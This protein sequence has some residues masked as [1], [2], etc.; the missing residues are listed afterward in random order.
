MKYRELNKH[1]KN[2]FAKDFL[3]IFLCE[4]GRW[5]LSFGSAGLIFVLLILAF[6]W[7]YGFIIIVSLLVCAYGGVSAWGHAVSNQNDRKTWRAHLADREKRIKE[8]R[9]QLELIDAEPNKQIDAGCL[10]YL[11]MNEEQKLEER[12]YYKNK[13]SQ[14][15]KEAELARIKLE[16]LGEKIP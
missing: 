16:G 8:I 6:R 3:K 10:K 13:I 12:R 7:K 1:D 9:E 4:V 2:L 14:Y 11:T 15:E 5:L